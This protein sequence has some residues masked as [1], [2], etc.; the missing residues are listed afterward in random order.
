MPSLWCVRVRLPNQADDR[1]HRLVPQ[2]PNRRN[3]ARCAVGVGSEQPEHEVERLIDLALLLGVD[4]SDFPPEALLRVDGQQ[5]LEQYSAALS[6]DLDL[7]M[8]RAGPGTGRG[9]RGEDGGNDN[10]SP[11]TSTA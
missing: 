10:A 7:G 5:L 3:N 4:V 11:C 8:E 9:R 6:V 2:S 1:V